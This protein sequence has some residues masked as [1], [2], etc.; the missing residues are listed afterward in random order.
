[1]LIKG[2]QQYQEAQKLANDLVKIASKSRMYDNTLFN[3][4]FDPLAMFLNK[5]M[6]I[7]GF[8]ADVAKTIENKMNPFGN[9]VA[10]IS[11][12]QAWVIACTA[13][14]NDVKEQYINL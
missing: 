3:L 4:Y 10:Y 9:Q 5:I 12:K 1:M 14:E 2:S 7:K 8:A 11:S 6:E 13:I